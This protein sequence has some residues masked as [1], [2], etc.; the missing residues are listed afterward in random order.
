MFDNKI[1]ISNNIIAYSKK[2]KILSKD[3]EYRLIKDWK[4]NQNQKAL[5]KIINAYLRLSV[6][7]ARKYTSY[8]IPLEDL[9]HE[10]LIGIMHALKKFEIEKGFRLSTYASWWIKASIQSYIL[11][12]WSIVKTG[13]T[14][15]QKTLFFNLKK[16]KKQISNNFDDFL[17]EEELQMIAGILNVKKKEV[18]NMESRLTSGDK[19]LNQTFDENNKN[20][21]MNL[22]ADPSPNS[23]EI[24]QKNLDDK[25]KKEW[26]K[27]AIER[28][29]DREKII[30]SARKLEEKAKSLDELGKEF[31]IS[32]ERVRQIESQALIKLQKNI[33]KI[34]NQDRD[35]F[36]N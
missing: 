4:N 2:N 23:E 6:S 14:T 26:L 36:I 28:L 3:H 30:I 32:K 18:E 13:S 25:V 27:Q 33:L 11:K 22:L 10:G 24:T 29:K 7:I 20:E 16:I 9:I 34:S 5:E 17:K 35:F 15:A 1:L 21:I 8:G 19:Y 31:G 12:N